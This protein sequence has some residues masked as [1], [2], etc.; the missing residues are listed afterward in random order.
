MI[1]LGLINILYLIACKRA[2]HLPK[3]EGVL[4]VGILFIALAKLTSLFAL[5]SIDFSILNIGSHL[6]SVYIVGLLV[7][8]LLDLVFFAI[9]KKLSITFGFKTYLFMTV[10]LFVLLVTPIICGLIAGTASIDPIHT[11]IITL[12]LIFLATGAVTM[13][14][15]KLSQAIGSGS[16]PQPTKKRKK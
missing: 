2:Q 11:F 5:E 16:K 1:G 10:V 4:A 7:F 6:A 8:A 15:G 12:A 13:I 14:M 9:L 3:H